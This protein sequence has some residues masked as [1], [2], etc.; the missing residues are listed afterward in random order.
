MRAVISKK[1]GSAN[2]DLPPG[3]FDFGLTD[4]QE[5]LARALHRES[6]IVDLMSQGAGGN[7]FSHYPDKLQEEFR[8]RLAEANTAYDAYALAVTW[9]QELVKVGKSDL[10][11]TWLRGSG[12]TCGTYALEVH[13]GYNPMINTWEAMTLRYTELPGMRYVTTAEEI[14][15]AKLAGDVAFYGHCQP[16][17]SVPRDFKSFD[18][19]YSRGLRSFMLTYDY[20]DNIGVG[21]AERVDAGLSLFG[22]DVVKYCNSKGIIVD[23]SHC[24]RLTT[25]D[26]CSHSTQP[27]NANHTSAKAVFAHRQA[28][29]DE[30]LKAIASTGGV[31]GIVTVPVMLTS[32]RRATIEHFLDQID[33]VS[34]LVGWQHVAIGSDWPLQAPDEVI[35]AVLPPES[36]GE[37]SDEGEGLD[38]ARRLGGFDDC[39]DLPNITRGLVGRGYADNEIRGI[40][41]ENALRV[42]GEVCG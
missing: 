42:I 13:D 30:M 31:I 38:A 36:R 37:N 34:N 40:L 12:L 27:V 33:Y 24:G 21:C 20:M 26:A 2:E 41:G 7:I 3:Q 29:S 6:I 14:R 1:G 10:L 18:E 25:L 32:V 4:A 28:K 17:F 11:C 9:P 35:R 15:H 16:F 8:N 5:T 23:V 22:V 19:A 39:R